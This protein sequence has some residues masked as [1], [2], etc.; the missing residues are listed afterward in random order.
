[1]S[2]GRN[3]SFRSREPGEPEAHRC[4]KNRE[5]KVGERWDWGTKSYVPITKWV[6]GQCGN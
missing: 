5:V 3:F 6:C 2:K 1:M 4:N